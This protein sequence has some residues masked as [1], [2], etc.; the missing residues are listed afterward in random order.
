QCADHAGIPLGGD[1][2]QD[3]PGAWRRHRDRAAAG[4]PRPFG[5]DRGPFHKGY[6]SRQHGGP[7]GLRHQRL[8]LTDLA[9]LAEAD[10][11]E[12]KLGGVI[13]AVATACDS[14]GE[15]D[16][17]RS[18]ALARFLLDHGCDGLNVLGTTGEATSYALAQR[19]AVMNAHHAARLPPDPLL[20]A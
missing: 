11:K 18:T 9:N 1:L 2:H 4:R 13:A 15:P 5:A 20:V 8:T 12:S 3:G 19:Q 6:G 14:V 17:A 10:M 7:R 16:C